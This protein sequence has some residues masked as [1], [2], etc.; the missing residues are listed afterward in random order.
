[1]SSPATPDPPLVGDE[2]SGQAVAPT[3]RGTIELKDQTWECRGPVDADLVKV[4]VSSNAAD[5]DAIVFAEN[6]TGRIGR[7]EVDTWSGDGIK[8]QNSA[9]VPHDLVIES[10]YVHCHSRTG[11]YHQ[12]GIQ[13]MGGE[14]I[15]FRN[16]SV[17]CGG[18]GVNAA[19]FI[20]QGGSDA[21]TPTDVVFEHGVLG[22]GAAHTILLASAV[23][24]GARST[25]I[26]PGRLDTYR[27]LPS[28]AKPDR[29]AERGADRRRS[30]LLNRN[31]RPL[32]GSAGTTYN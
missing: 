18:V 30:A 13:A 16:L 25:V 17:L 24:S 14:R 28:A 12:D 32:D 19:L 8:V 9:P 21:S 26:C 4:T 29:Q 22:P 10:G 2:H 31:S 20:A 11:S 6:C 1:M 15:T 23:R 3:I 5:V 7:V 27:V